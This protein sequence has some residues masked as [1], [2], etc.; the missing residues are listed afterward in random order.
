[1]KK[2]L[3]SLCFIFFST[4]INAAIINEVLIKN[5]NRISKETII[6]YGKIQIGKNYNDQDINNILK[7]LYDTN[8]F[9]N[10]SLN[11]DNGSLIIDVEENQII[12]T[13]IIEGVKSSEIEA[14]ILKNLFSKDKAPF[15]IEKVKSDK[16]R[17]IT[18]LNSSGYYL[19]KVDVRTKNNS[20]D[21]INLIFEIDLGE[22]AKISK[23]EFVGD[24]RVKDRI[25][26]SIIISEEAKFWK[27]V[28]TNKFLNKSKIER[29]KRLLKNYYLNNGY[30][31]VQ[32]ESVTAKFSDED[33]SFKLTYKINSGEIYNIGNVKLN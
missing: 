17:I 26:R 14:S 10:I 19:A 4:A 22:K 24:K 5:N 32:V 13:V 30:Y 16:S 6:T 31:D 7:N 33:S 29:D 23:I 12:Q 9:K 27:V 25:L 2:F 20:N 15:L 11:I 18:S 8:F 1:M 21:T 28:T 3:L